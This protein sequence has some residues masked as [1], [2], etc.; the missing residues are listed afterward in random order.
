MKFLNN[1]ADT[2]ETAFVYVNIYLHI[3]INRFSG[4]V[5]RQFVRASGAL[6]AVQYPLSFY[7]DLSQKLSRLSVTAAVDKRLGVT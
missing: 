3:Q 4:Y 5:V 2:L 6:V 1:H 7:I